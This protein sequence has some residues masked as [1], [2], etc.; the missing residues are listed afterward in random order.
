VGICPKPKLFYTKNCNQDL[1]YP[2]AKNVDKSDAE[3]MRKRMKNFL[4]GVRVSICI[5][6]KNK[7]PQKKTFEVKLTVQF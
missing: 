6:R 5:A 2:P 7:C 4:R 3:F 1:Q